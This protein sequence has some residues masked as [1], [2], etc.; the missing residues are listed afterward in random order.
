[1]AKSEKFIHLLDKMRDIHERKNAG[2]AGKDAKDPWK[3]FRMSEMLG[4]SPFKGC[5]VRMSDKF[6]RVANLSKDE[7]NDQV[8]EPIVDTLIDLANYALIAICLYEE[9]PVITD[10]FDPVLLDEKD[11][12]TDIQYDTVDANGSGLAKFG[13]MI[14]G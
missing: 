11:L 8:G 13:E 6:I 7:S 5:L 1:M 3:N 4:V 14:D 9:D 2:Y 10:I 12:E